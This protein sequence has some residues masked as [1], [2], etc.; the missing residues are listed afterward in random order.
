VILLLPNL[1]RS[2]LVGQN[3]NQV[4]ESHF[5]ML[6]FDLA[7]LDPTSPRKADLSR[8]ESGRGACLLLGE[9]V[10]FALETPGVQPTSFAFPTSNPSAGQ[11]TATDADGDS[12]AWLARLSRA[13]PNRRVDPILIDGIFDASVQSRIISRIK[14]PKGRLRVSGRS[15][16]VCRFEPTVDGDQPY[17]QQIAT[18]LALE[19]DNVEGPVAILTTNASTGAGR[20]VVLR[21]GRRREVLEIRLRNSE[22]DDF[23]A[24]PLALAPAEV[25]DFDVFYDLVVPANGLRRRSPVQEIEGGPSVRNPSLCPPTVLD[26]A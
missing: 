18:E 5:P 8:Q 7:D 6:E 4:L 2:R 10:T 19:I 15:K 26:F 20:T 16:A 1:V 23:L 21:P 11:L 14:L 25:S 3:Q 9:S 22:L 17:R 12:L 13:A 24:V